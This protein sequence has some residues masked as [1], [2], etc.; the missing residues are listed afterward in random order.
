MENLQAAIPTGDLSP[1]IAVLLKSL[2]PTGSE[3]PRDARDQW[4]RIFEMTLDNLYKDKE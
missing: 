4:M 2:P 1:M 3:W